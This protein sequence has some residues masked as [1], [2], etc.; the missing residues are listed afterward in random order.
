[1][2]VS[3]ARSVRVRAIGGRV[4]FGTALTFAVV[5]V[6]LVP[7][8]EA[9]QA[10]RVPA[11]LR[12][13]YGSDWS[14]RGQIYAVDPAGRLPTR[15]LTFGGCCG[16]GLQSVSPDGKRI[17]FSGCTDGVAALF[18]ANADGRSMRRLARVSKDCYSAGIVAAWSADARQIAYAIGGSLHLATASGRT[19]RVMRAAG[20]VDS[21]GFADNLA[22][23]PNGGSLAIRSLSGELLV[24]RNGSLRSIGWAD[25]F[26]W[27]PTGRWIAYETRE[28]GQGG[29]T[30]YL[31]RPD[32]SGQRAE[33]E[34][35]DDGEARERAR[36]VRARLRRGGGKDRVEKFPHGSF[37]TSH[38][39]LYPQLLFCAAAASFAAFLASMS[40][41]IL[42]AASFVI[43]NDIVNCL[44]SLLN[45]RLL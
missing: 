4:V 11:G 6:S 45:F 42:P 37:F 12:L 43:S 41:I 27:S 34:R 32:G 14:G 24:L 44:P 15:Q 17:V 20:Q 3:R 22:W 8:A 19:D 13:L 10:K 26:A 36:R 28:H 31:M 9:R 2:R 7:A 5:M 29:S 1:M 30:L 21:S 23:S 40:V 33:H 35:A 18:V 25:E 16:H 39:F 38:G